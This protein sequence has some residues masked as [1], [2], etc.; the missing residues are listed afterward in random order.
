MYPSVL[1]T[2]STLAR[3][4][5]PGVETLGLARICALRMRVM[6]SLIGSCVDMSDPPYQLDLTSPGT[7]PLEPRSR[8]AMRLSVFLR[9]TDRGRPVISQRLRIR[10]AD[11]LRGSSASFSVAA[12]RSS[13]GFFLSAMMAFSFARLGASFLVIR[14]RRLFFSIELFF[15]MLGSWISAFERLVSV[16]LPEREIECGQQGS[17]LVVS[18]RRGAYRDVHAPRLPGLVEVDFGENDVFLDAE[19]VVAAA[20]EA[21]RVQGAEAGHGRERDVHQ[22][23]DELVHLGLAQRHLAADRLVLAQLEGRD[24]DARIGHHGLLAGDQRKIGGGRLGLLAVVDGLADAHV[25]HD[26]VQAR[27]LHDIGIAELFGQLAADAL[28]IFRA[29]ARDVC[30]L[31]HRSLLPSFWQR[32]PSCHPHES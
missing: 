20:V 32:V 26:L 10:V 9:Y 27:H 6:R 12:N 23:I 14:L 16:S 24:R 2:S 15:A 1:S 18:A 3:I 21:L 29:Q 13:I 11:E 31:S 22:A 4:F 28:V 5:E 25:E 8:S 17:S 30:G 7:R 19:R